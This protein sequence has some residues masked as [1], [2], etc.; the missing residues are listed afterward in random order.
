[1]KDSAIGIRKVFGNFDK[2]EIVPAIK[3]VLYFFASNLEPV[4]RIW[5]LQLQRW[6][7]SRL[8]TYKVFQRSF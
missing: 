4:L 3:K 6:R 5:N 2:F 7:C 8:H 1:L